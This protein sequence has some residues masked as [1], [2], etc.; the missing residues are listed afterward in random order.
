MPRSAFFLR[1]SA[2]A[3][4]GYSNLGRKHP[5]VGFVTDIT[6]GLQTIQISLRIEDHIRPLIVGGWRCIRRSGMIKYIMNIHTE[7]DALSFREFDA[8]A[9]SQIQ[10][11]ASRTG[12][13]IWVEVASYARPGFLEDYDARVAGKSKRV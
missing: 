12:E 7:V 2:F 9:H 5:V 8:F 10:S 13:R 1:L 3:L 6:E 11:P 4:E